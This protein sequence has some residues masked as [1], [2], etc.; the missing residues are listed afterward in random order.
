MTALTPQPSK[1]WL[2][3]TQTDKYNDNLSKRLSVISDKTNLSEKWL[4]INNTSNLS[5][6]LPVINDMNIKMTCVIIISIK[7]WW[8]V[9]LRVCI[10]YDLCGCLLNQR[11]MK[12]CHQ[13]LV[14][15][16]LIQTFKIRSL[17]YLTEAWIQTFKK[18]LLANQCLFSW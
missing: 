8:H 2:F 1:A 18:R 7:I 3:A 15:A 16:P 14:V 4:V 13:T 10:A 11:R 6:R 17:I 5:E 12:P 9:W